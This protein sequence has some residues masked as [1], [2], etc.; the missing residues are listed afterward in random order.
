MIRGVLFDMDGVLL[1]TE[2]LGLEIMIR[3]CARRGYAFTRE[4]YISVLGCT[5]QRGQE[6]LSRTFGED[7]PFFELSEEFH[8]E[9]LSVAQ[10][11]GLPPKPGLR[12]CIEG[13][14]ARGIRTALATSTARPVV[15]GYFKKIPL[16]QN[17]FDAMVCGTEGGRSKPAPD[18][19]LEAARRLSLAPGD[20]L[21]VE[22]SQN[23][24]CSL[25]A[26]GC[27]SVMVP[28]LLPYSDGLAGVVNYR[29]SNLSQVCAL[30]DR[31]N[32]GARTRA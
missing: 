7:F 27:V 25:T 26:A 18:I 14:K 12:A 22:D 4:L 29:L 15:E 24:L 31:L 21:G 1:D 3:L 28:D 23:G 13:L 9:L 6:I 10:R 20:C 17:A 11:E 16:L 30:V 8:R 19:Y 2:R 32:A 5:T